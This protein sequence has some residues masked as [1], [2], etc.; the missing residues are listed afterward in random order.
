MLFRRNLMR[1][2]LMRGDLCWRMSLYLLNFFN[3]WYY[4]LCWRNLFLF[5]FSHRLF[6]RGLSRNSFISWDWFSSFSL[7]YWCFLRWC[8]SWRLF[9]CLLL[10]TLL[11][12]LF[13]LLFLFWALLLLFYHF[14]RWWHILALWFRCFSYRTFSSWFLCWP[15]RLNLFF[16]F[17]FF[18]FFWLNI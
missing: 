17:L 5:F 12:Y 13:F 3:W 8:L 7:W 2:S 14:L 4:F 16:Y 6:S 18:L 10:R 11:L 15:F 1:R 9:M